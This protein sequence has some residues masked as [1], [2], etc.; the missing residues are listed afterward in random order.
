MRCTDSFDCIHRELNN[1]SLIR[2]KCVFLSLS[3]FFNSFV[4]CEW[5]E[6]KTI[7][8]IRFACNSSTHTHTP[9]NAQLS[10]LTHLFIKYN[11]YS[12]CGH[13][14]QCHCLTIAILPEAMLLL[15][16]QFNKWTIIQLI[17]SFTR[18]CIHILTPTLVGCNDGRRMPTQMNPFN[19]LNHFKCN[20]NEMIGLILIPM[21][22]L[23]S[24]SDG[25]GVFF[26][27]SIIFH[28]AWKRARWITI[29]FVAHLFSTG[30]Y[31][32]WLNARL[33]LWLW[34]YR[35]EWIMKW[36]I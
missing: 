3:R 1:L 9:E 35:N 7:I 6:L 27:F 10:D 28:S 30:L 29:P 12:I 24:L 32:H 11:F 19:N 20:P 13:C 18:E 5:V 22:M 14:C 26:F 31:H 16:Q 33:R 23:M 2:S 25:N 8:P 21:P 34:F 4:G 36:F 15:E 17:I